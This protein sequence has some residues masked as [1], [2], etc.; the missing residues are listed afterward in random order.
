MSPVLE[1]SLENPSGVYGQFATRTR[2]DE[3]VCIVGDWVLRYPDGTFEVHKP[4]AFETAFEAVPPSAMPWIDTWTDGRKAKAEV[5][6][7]LR[8]RDR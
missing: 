5:R 1:P 7:C 2:N 4:D 8:T 3:N 6:R